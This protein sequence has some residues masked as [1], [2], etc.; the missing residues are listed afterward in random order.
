[1]QLLIQQDGT[2]RC[3]YAEVFPL[4]TLG[5][6]DIARGSHVEPDCDGQWW[7][8]LSPVDGPK[9]GPF[10]QRSQALQAEVHWLE[11]HWLKEP[12]TA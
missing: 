10:A 8:D 6:L 3:L 7:A 5:P 4:A 11:T 12:L 1:M 2:I 9:L